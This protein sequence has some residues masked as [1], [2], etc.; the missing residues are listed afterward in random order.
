MGG[1]AVILSA[2]FEHPS[3]NI[4]IREHRKHRAHRYI[5]PPPPT[6]TFGEED[7]SLFHSG[8]TAGSAPTD[9]ICV[10][11]SSL[12]HLEAS[13]SK[14]P[15]S[16]YSEKREEGHVQPREAAFIP[17]PGPPLSA[18]WRKLSSGHYRLHSDLGGSGQG[19]DSYSAQKAGNARG[20]PLLL[21]SAA[22][23]TDG[24]GPGAVCFFFCSARGR[25][26]GNGSNG[27][28]SGVVPRVPFS[29]PS[30]SSPFLS[31]SPSS[32]YFLPPPPP[33]PP[34]PLLP[35]SSC[36]HLPVGFQGREAAAAARAAGGGG[37][38]GGGGDVG[39]GGGRGE[40]TAP[41][42]VHPSSSSSSS[43]GISS[44]SGSNGGGSSSSSSSGSSSSGGSS[45]RRRLFFSPPSLQ[46]LLL[47]AS[48]GP[49]LQPQQPPQP[50]LLL[51]PA[52]CSLWSYN[53][54]GTAGAARAVGGVGGGGP[55][56]Y[57]SS[58]FSS[59]SSLSSNN[60]KIQQQQHQPKSSFLSFAASSPLSLG[61]DMED[62][63]SNSTGCFR[64]FTECFL[65][66][67][68]W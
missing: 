62:E 54:L 48:V 45:R 3:S 44:G 46:G 59:S 24:P 18:D 39:G 33:P 10:S 30:S 13:L 58:S 14:R 17:P 35:S 60:C 1:T 41:L 57:T 31:S 49:R 27:Y 23:G 64:R 21:A 67:S 66:T 16:N 52:V 37:R 63:P 4:Y 11:G 55:A 36:F 26:G 2:A 47:P 25:G 29:V 65:N 42:I 9:I 51:S 34:P 53:F 12:P 38:G 28:S 20:F 56:Y 61:S 40:E 15:A 68:F 43:S 5:R 8:A 22:R 50:R 7:E 6:F 32:F 19:G